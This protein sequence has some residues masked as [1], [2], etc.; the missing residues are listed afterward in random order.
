MKAK[1]IK[2]LWFKIEQ[3]KISHTIADGFLI[4]IA[5]FSKYLPKEENELIILVIL[6]SNLILPQI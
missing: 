5:R 4:N 2:I 6:A 1:E 3:E